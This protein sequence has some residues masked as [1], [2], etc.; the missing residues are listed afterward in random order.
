MRCPQ[1]RFPPRAPWSPFVG[2]ILLVSLMG[3]TEFRYVGLSRLST[4]VRRRS[5]HWKTA[6]RGKKTPFADWLRCQSDREAAFF[7]SLELVMSD[8]LDDLELRS[9]GGL[10]GFVP[11]VIACSISPTAGS[12]D[13]ATCGLRSSAERS[14]TAR[15]ARSIP[16]RDA[17]QTTPCGAVRTLRSR[18]RAGRNSAAAPTP[19]RLTRT[20]GNSVPHI[21]H[22]GAK[23]R[24]RLEL[25]SLNRGVASG[26]PTSARRPAMKRGPRCRLCGK[27]A[28][29]R[30]A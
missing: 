25:F 21:R 15:G 19:G 14:A 2:I 10:Q 13:V 7:Q 18:K 16:I 29:S 12:D 6:E 8:D 5:E 9:N 3:S 23:H 11:R 28:P 20:S 1:F 30:R 26:I 22:S 17:E 24:P 4:I 27:G